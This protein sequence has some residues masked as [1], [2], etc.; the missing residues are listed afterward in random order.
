MLIL[1]KRQS[2][3]NRL[4]TPNFRY[5]CNPYLAERSVIDL[6]TVRMVML[7]CR[8]LKFDNEKQADLVNL[9]VMHLAANILD[10]HS[11]CQHVCTFDQSAY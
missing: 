11:S 5:P 2:G 4:T 9:Q 8:T 10:L 1:L 6:P 3:L 7:K